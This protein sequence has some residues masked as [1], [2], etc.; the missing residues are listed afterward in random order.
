[1]QLFIF[2]TNK[3]SRRSN[4]KIDLLSRY[5][6]L[7][8]ITMFT[9]PNP[10]VDDK[11]ISLQQFKGTVIGDNLVDMGVCPC[12][13]LTADEFLTLNEPKCLLSR[14]QSRCHSILACESDDEHDY[15][16]DDEANGMTGVLA[17]GATYRL[18]RCLVEGIL[19][20]KGS[21]KDWFFSRGFKARW[22][23]L[24]LGRVEGY[25]ME[26]PLLCVS[27]YPK[28]I[29]A[30][31]VIVLDSTVVLAVDLPDKTKWSCHR[32]EIR[33]ASTKANDSLPM[34]RTF[35]A[36]DR[37]AR[38]AWMYAISQALLYYE[39][40]KA[41]RRQTTIAPHQQN[42]SDSNKPNLLRA[43]SF[44]E[45]WRG[46]D[47]FSFLGRSIKSPTHSPKMTPRARIAS[48][49]RPKQQH[50]DKN[51]RGNVNLPGV[52]PTVRV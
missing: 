24:A 8:I 20:K 29:S 39:K 49:P 14:N 13:H 17:K 52:T 16:V 36:P 51:S 28:S 46:G 37:K 5:E 27:W 44:D 42:K 33:H 38:D 21:G 43:R 10:K 22:T 1:M 3:V 25:D 2:P 30:S 19:Y 15:D 6:R 26:V 32:F 50:T 35:M 4:K 18:T 11:T 34:T 12:C 41:T 40:E 47:R 9:T 31:T 45:V 48:P 23:S 7:P